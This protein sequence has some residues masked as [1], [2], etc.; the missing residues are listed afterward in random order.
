MNKK[1]LMI[2]LALGL[3]VIFA[4]VGCDSNN[5]D[6]TPTVTAPAAPTGVTATIVSPT[7]VRVDWTASVL[8][9]APDGYKIERRTAEGS[10]GEIG[11]V[12]DSVET[13]NDNNQAAMGSGTT[14]LYRVGAYN[15]GGTTYSSTATVTLE[16]FTE[17]LDGTWNALDAINQTGADSSSI[18]FDYVQAQGGFIYRR[19]DYIEEGLYTA[20]G[21]AITWSAL[22]IN[23]VAADTSYT[24]NYN[25]ATSGLTMTVEYNYGEG[26][27]DVDFIFVNPPPVN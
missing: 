24:W 15:A 23:G 4:L 22:R 14:Y 25:M 11:S 3:S 10:W 26:P 19:T 9:E 13:Y 1:L 21:T 12:G 6:N 27:F 16:T 18:I 2:L 17:L 7:V 20:T 8:D 5:N